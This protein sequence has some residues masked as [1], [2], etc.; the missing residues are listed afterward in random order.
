MNGKGIQET[1]V[2]ERPYPTSLVLHERSHTGEKPYKCE[3][4]DKSFRYKPKL[5]LH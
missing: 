2:E 4:C 5:A 3:V 1:Q